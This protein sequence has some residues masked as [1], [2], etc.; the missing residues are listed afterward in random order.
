[1]SAT[2]IDDSSAI[3]RACSL[4]DLSMGKG[5]C[6]NPKDCNKQNIFGTH[7]K[8]L[9]SHTNQIVLQGV[10]IYLLMFTFFFLNI[11]LLC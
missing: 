1:M 7:H 6:K 10:N 5:K 2:Q 8:N 11:L 3:R 9:K 4:S